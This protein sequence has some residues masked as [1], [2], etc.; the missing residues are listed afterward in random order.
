VE[1][2]ILMITGEPS[3]DMRGGELLKELKSILPNFDFWGI[4][5]DHMKAEGAELTEHVRNLSIVGV[6]EALKSLGKVREQYL[7]ITRHIDKRKPSLAILIDYPGF[8]LKVAKYL[9]SQN[10]PVIYYVIPQIW[11]WGG[12]RINAIKKYIDKALVLFDFERELL[13][14]HNINVEFTGHPLIEGFPPP[15]SLFSKDEF[16]LSLLPGSR[17][18]E[19]ENLLPIMLDAAEIINTSLFPNTIPPGFPENAIC[20]KKLK[21]M[22]AQN[23]NVSSDIYD[24]LI[25][26]HKELDLH[27]VLNDTIRTLENCSFSLVASGTA[28]LEVAVME[29]PMVITYKAPLL[30]SLPYKLI[31]KTPFI[32]LVNV[33]SG[34]EICPELLQKNATAEKLAEKTIEIINS[35]EKLKTM[36]KALKK[37]RESLG[38]KGASR[39]AA[40]VINHFIQEKNL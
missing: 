6:T 19:V 27:L 20:N 11:A 36:K 31:V 34:K 21:I 7:N 33:I 8:N 25:E 9:T 39:R 16:I 18:S 13:E 29:K 40:N 23:S 1:K 14:Q 22:I 15:P 5:G 32:G 38:E 12:W 3:G 24:L 30:N 4:G 2:N 17:K 10:I 35:P 28:T 37:V 26:K